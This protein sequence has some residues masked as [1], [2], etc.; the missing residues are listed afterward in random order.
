MRVKFK[1][2]FKESMADEIHR[3]I[4]ERKAREGEFRLGM[5]YK[6]EREYTS[7]SRSIRKVVLS[8]ENLERFIADFIA[9]VPYERMADKYYMSSPTLRRI[10]RNHPN[11]VRA[12]EERDVVVNRRRAEGMRKRWADAERSKAKL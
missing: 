5:E 12:K 4:N 8:D 2:L 3:N 10:I 1:P 7:K 11:F 6:P 9:G